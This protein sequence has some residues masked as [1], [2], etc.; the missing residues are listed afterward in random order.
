MRVGNK[1]T[2]P[3][4]RNTADPSY[5]RE[6]KQAGIQGTVMLEIVITEEGIPSRIRVL[7]PLGY[8]LDEMAAEAIK[9]WRFHPGRLEG[10]PVPTFA[11]VEVNFRLNKQPFDAETELRRTRFNMAAQ[12]LNAPLAPKSD[13]AI[14]A[15]RELAKANYPPALYVLG[16]LM[17]KG[18]GVEKDVPHGDELIRKAADQDYPPAVFTVGMA[19]LNA[20][21]DDSSKQS[22]LKMIDIAATLG[23]YP[24]QVFTGEAYETAA[25]GPPEPA[26]AE[27]AFRLC[28]AAGHGD[29]QYRLG[30]LLYNRA[31]GKTSV[32]VESAAW[33][34]LAARNG[35]DPAQEL[36]KAI[37]LTP[38]E[39]VQEESLRAKLQRQP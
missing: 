34:H 4:V 19:A 23:H 33:L 20:A 26:R 16:D 1:V 39:T 13:G 3:R 38:Q 24:A 25:Y 29:C 35:Q 22:A 10:K 18:D 27:R 21:Q 12:I 28:A 31:A 15:V 36:L 5:T 17:R 6:A 11:N 30:R 37:K 32:V 14:N 2:A 9:K 7:S 8:G